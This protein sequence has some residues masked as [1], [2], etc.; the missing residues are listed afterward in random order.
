MLQ[1][2]INSSLQSKTRSREKSK[3]SVNSSLLS[4][5]TPNGTNYS[6]SDLCVEDGF[7][8][9]SERDEFEEEDEEEE[10][11]KEEDSDHWDNSQM[12]AWVISFHFLFGHFHFMS[13]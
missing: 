8:L 2:T 5:A 3:A 12:I 9:D 6:N 10:E 7:E 11:E 1:L 4:D 13:R